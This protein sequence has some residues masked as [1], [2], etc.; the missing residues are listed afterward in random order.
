[1]AEFGHGDSTENRSGV[2]IWMEA[3]RAAEDI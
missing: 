1:M 2:K 3:G